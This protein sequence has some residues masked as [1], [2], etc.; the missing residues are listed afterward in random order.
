M[1]DHWKLDKPWY[2]THIKWLTTRVLLYMIVYV[3][4]CIYFVIMYL[5]IYLF[6]N[7]L[8]NP[9]ASAEYSKAQRFIKSFLVS[10]FIKNIQKKNELLTYDKNMNIKLFK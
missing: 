9:Q 2:L 3:Y 5:F 7:H 4:T 6:N 8:D 10:K 1:D